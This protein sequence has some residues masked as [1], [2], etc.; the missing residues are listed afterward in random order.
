M[1]SNNEQNTIVAE[2]TEIDFLSTR[3]DLS[4]VYFQ[5][6]QNPKFDSEKCPAL[7]CDIFIPRGFDYLTILHNSKSV[8]VY[9][10]KGLSDE[11]II[12]I[13]LG[14]TGN[15]V[16]VVSPCPIELEDKCIVP[17]ITKC[18]IAMF[19][20]LGAMLA[21]SM[22]IRCPQIVLL[23]ELVEDAKSCRGITLTNKN[24]LASHVKIYE[25]PRFHELDMFEA[26]AH[27]FRHCWQG[28]NDNEKYFS[29]FKGIEEFHSNREQYHQQL[30]E[31]D[32]IA[33]ALRFIRAC[34]G[35]SLSANT[36]YPRVNQ[37][38]E[39]YAKT[40]D[41]SLFKPFAGIL[42]GYANLIR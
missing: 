38:V 29:R 9:T 26:L 21:R 12:K 30:A 4:E 18:N 5:L 37:K 35:L 40:L 41:A 20:R 15:Y 19:Y 1:K 6:G 7:I 17:Y 13:V 25:N 27:E 28:E 16:G 39:R 22:H 31:I 42:R 14:E 10:R 24:M 34:T 2:K 33:Y 11:D 32:A 23:S 8:L 3:R 36:V